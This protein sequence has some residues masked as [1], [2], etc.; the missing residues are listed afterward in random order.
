MP[1]YV[2]SCLFSALS[3]RMCQ[4]LTGS[5]HGSD[6]FFSS[7]FSDVSYGRIHFE[8]LVLIKSQELLKARAFSERTAVHRDRVKFRGGVAILFLLRKR[9]TQSDTLSRVGLEV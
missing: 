1:I 9:K 4:V 7:I 5:V 8:I 6:Y 2:N 3:D